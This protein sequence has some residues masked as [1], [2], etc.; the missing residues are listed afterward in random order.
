MGV[1]GDDQRNHGE[2]RN[3]IK[4]VLKHFTITQKGN[5]DITPFSLSPGD[6]PGSMVCNFLMVQIDLSNSTK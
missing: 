1:A 3:A 6:A 4:S 2:M 5:T